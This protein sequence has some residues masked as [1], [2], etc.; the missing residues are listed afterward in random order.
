MNSHSLLEII[1]TKFDEQD[2]D[3]DEMPN[4]FTHSSNYSNDNAVQLLKLKQNL[5]SLFSLNCQSLNAK[6]HQLQI[7]LQYFQESQCHFSVIALQETWLS[8]EHDTSILELDGYKFIYKPKLASH[9]GGVGFYVTDS[10]DYQ[11]LPVT[12]DDVLCDSLFIEICLRSTD[13]SQIDKVILGN[14]YRPPRADNES[15]ELFLQKLERVIMNFQN[16]KQVILMGDF[17]IDLLKI[18]EKEQI[19]DFFDMLVSNG[20]IPRIT[21]PTRVTEHSKTLIDNYF[22][23]LQNLKNLS[24]G[25]LKSQISD[26]YP[27]F[28]CVDFLKLNKQKQKYIKIRKT[29]TI[30]K[31]RFK[32]SIADT[33]KIEKFDSEN[34]IANFALLQKNLKSSLDTYLPFKLVKY[35]KHKHKK[36]NWIT[37]GI[38]KSIKFRDSL[39]K[40]F[41]ETPITDQLHNT[42]KL[43]L[44]TYNRILKKSIREAK[45]TYY[46]SRFTK[47]QNDIKNT[48]RTVKGIIGSSEQTDFTPRQFII[49]NVPCSDSKMIA[50]EFNRY[51]TSIGPSLAST[52]T[53]P[54]NKTFRDTLVKKITSSFELHTV[55]EDHVLKIIDTLKNKTSCGTDQLSNNLLKYIKYEVC[56][57]LTLIINQCMTAGIFPDEMK[58][59]K[60]LPIFKKGDDSLFGNYRPVSLL[61][62]VSKVFERIIH[63]QLYQYFIDNKLFY[64]NQYGFRQNHSTEMAAMDLIDRIVC[65]MDNG[66]TPI[67]IFLDLSKAFD[68]LDHGILREKL[69]YYG[70]NGTALELLSSYLKNRKQIVL[71]DEKFSS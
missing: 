30:Q 37:Q 43:N 2:K 21:L 20:Y 60:V 10:I 61:P 7:Y 71:Y 32:Q 39:Y 17:N 55:T 26:H 67:S 48:W 56:K 38:I 46:T 40:R 65:E 41:K 64:Q 31:E 1:N 63:N 70:I 69:C 18:N 52:I 35:S 68:T 24:A 47:Y 27:Y 45:K 28:M 58:I 53:P 9:H 33:C 4:L 50:N 51:F 8:S 42:L 6:F 12:V 15:Y 34:P 19:S 14:I 25:I 5:F 66:N 13:E 59:A 62:S 23:K 57:P 3:G 44:I 11:V 36:S 16:D 29:N 54:A 49:G 22:V